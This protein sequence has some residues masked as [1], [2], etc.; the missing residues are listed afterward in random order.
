M[1]AITLRLIALPAM[2]GLAPLVWVI[3]TVRRNAGLGRALA[4]RCLLSLA[5]QGLKLR[6]DR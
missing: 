6:Q 4:N 3:A 5:R 2:L 1:T